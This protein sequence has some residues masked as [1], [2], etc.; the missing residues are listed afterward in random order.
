MHRPTQLAERQFAMPMLA[1]ADAPGQHDFDHHASP[2]PLHVRRQHMWHMQQAA[3]EAKSAEIA[4]HK[5][6]ENHNSL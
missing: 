1:E 5:E 6:N 3:A 4:A 2:V